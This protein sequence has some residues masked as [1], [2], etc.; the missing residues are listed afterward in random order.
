MTLAAL[1]RVLH[2]IQHKAWSR[3]QNL[4]RLLGLMAFAWMVGGLQ[5][6]C[7]DGCGQGAQDVPPITQLYPNLNHA[8]NVDWGE[9]N[10]MTFV[11]K[12]VVLLNDGDTKL[13]IS[14]ILLAVGDSV[15]ANQ[16]R[17][18]ITT[19][20]PDFAES[21]Y[22]LGVDNDLRIRI[23]FEGYIEG[24]ANDTL[25]IESNDPDQPRLEL[26]LQAAVVRPIL[27]LFPT[28]LIY[29]DVFTG[30]A[31][32]KTLDIKNSGKGTLAI[33]ELNFQGD[34]D[35]EFSYTLPSSFQL[36]QSL[37]GGTGIEVGITYSPKNDGADNVTLEVVS[38]DPKQPRQNVTLSANGQVDDP[39]QVVILSPYEGDTYYVGSSINL[40][41]KVVDDGLDLSKMTILWLSSTEGQ[42]CPNL[43]PDAEGNFQCQATFTEAGDQT[44]TLTALDA[45][46]QQA[47]P[48]SVKI[49]IWDLETPLSY[50][51]SGSSETSLYAYTPDD[52]IQIFVVDGQN[53][54]ISEVCVNAIDDRREAEPPR[55]CQAKYGDII[56]I[57]VYDRY[58][59]GF[60]IPALHLWYGREDEY[61]QALIEEPISRS[62]NAADYESFDLGDCLPTPSRDEWYATHGE[63]EPPPDCLVYLKEVVVEIPPPEPQGPEARRTR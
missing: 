27:N 37:S 33:Y 12:E 11:T 63:D 18:T 31:S 25:V 24:V 30:V 43:K 28:K 48:V 47:I 36:G 19:E 58:G 5:T 45:S 26:P 57:K 6:G 42:L 54:L 51:I 32:T 56:Q 38:S 23:K 34:V 9:V 60:G 59:S 21:P 17:F 50:V 4:G 39:P 53:P 44:I 14:N 46:N 15:G 61:D 20:L 10:L 35:G 40:R 62:S 52:N 55:T 1:P 8:E 2:T 7:A 49:V 16:N 29:D 41:G 3:W 22:L 13:S